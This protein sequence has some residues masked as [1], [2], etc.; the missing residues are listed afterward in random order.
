RLFLYQQAGPNTSRII[1]ADRARLDGPDSSGKVV[2][3]LSGFSQHMFNDL[4]TPA[5]M[6]NNR[7]CPRCPS[8]PSDV[9]QISMNLRD[10]TQVMRL[11]QLLPFPVRGTDPHEQ[12]VFE[13]LAKPHDATSTVYL[14]NMELL[15]ERITRSLLCL[16]APFIA[17]LAVG[18][19]TR[20]TSYLALPL[21][22]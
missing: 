3:H 7:L 8:L 10:M 16:L 18:C 4:E 22:C 20:I 21:A 15:G 12:T 9:P 14:T 5:P 11:D 1:T 6:P 19:T 2:L 17:L 13:Q